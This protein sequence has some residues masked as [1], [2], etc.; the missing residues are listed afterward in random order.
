MYSVKRQ[1]N[2]IVTSRIT[3]VAVVY[4]T[5]SI[6]SLKKTHCLVFSISFLPN[7]SL[8]SISHHFRLVSCA[9][10]DFRLTI[11]GS[12]SGSVRASVKN[13]GKKGELAA[14]IEAFL[15]SFSFF[16]SIFVGRGELGN[17]NR[18]SNF[19]FLFLFVL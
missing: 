16:L 6:D 18:G 17:R 10:L 8:A 3:K 4:G 12:F 5:V 2:I 13:R 9:F 19:P 15:F 1:L 7:F 14:L 11:R